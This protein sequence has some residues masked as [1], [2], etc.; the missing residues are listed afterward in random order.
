[1][2]QSHFALSTRGVIQRLR[3]YVRIAI[4]I[5]TD[6][7]SHAEKAGDLPTS[8]LILQRRVKLGDLIQERGVVIAE[9]VLNFVD[10]RQL[11]KTQQ[12]R[13]PK[14]RDPRPQLLFIVMQSPIQQGLPTLGAP[15]R[16]A[17]RIAFSEQLRDVT[18]HIQNAFTLH[19]GR[20]CRQDG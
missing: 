1:M 8:Q 11:A 18:L 16:F 15:Q 6:P 12:P 9:R 10:H 20:V 7:V 17:Y 4:A 14:Q 3:G 13:L 19:L 2:A 5:P